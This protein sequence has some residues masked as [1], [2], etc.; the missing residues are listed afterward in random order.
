MYVKK[1]RVGWRG[2][3]EGVLNVSPV[4]RPPCL[5][6]SVPFGRAITGSSGRHLKTSSLIFLKFPK[7]APIKLSEGETYLTNV[8]ER[9]WCSNSAAFGTSWCSWPREADVREGG[10]DPQPRHQILE[11]E[12][13]HSWLI[14]AFFI[15]Y[16]AMPSE[17]LFSS[18][19]TP[20][21][22]YRSKTRAPASPDLA[23]KFTYEL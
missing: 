5:F 3:E 21:W 18:Q 6:T 17:Y 16:P 20:Y 4:E 22:W 19:Q 1:Q 10:E 12:E 7:F 8:S 14:D 15:S 23:M 11:P 2:G 13:A 9:L